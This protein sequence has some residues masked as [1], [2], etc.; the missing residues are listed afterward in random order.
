MTAFGKSCGPAPEV[1][2]L[3]LAFEPGSGNVLHK[4]RIERG[5]HTFAYR[6]I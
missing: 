5:V 4:T 2:P 1:E 3:V 6:F